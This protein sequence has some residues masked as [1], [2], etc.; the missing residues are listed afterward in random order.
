M[1][2]TKTSVG[3]VDGDYSGRP[4]GRPTPEELAA[5]DP[6]A[7]PCE[8]VAIYLPDG[9]RAIQSIGGYY[10]LPRQNGWPD[11]DQPVDP[12]TGERIELPDQADRT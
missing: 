10:Y 3:S 5:S 8:V 11:Y 1:G 7:L 6:H 9:R 12:D 2:K 4:L